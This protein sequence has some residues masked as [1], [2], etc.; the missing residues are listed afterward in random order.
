MPRLTPPLGTVTRKQAVSVL[1]REGVIT[2]AS[3]LEKLKG[4]KRV[5]LEGRTHG[6][7]PEDQILSIINS[8]RALQNQPPL[9]SIFDEEHKIVC[10]Q[11][12]T[13]DMLGVYTVAEK[14]FGHTTS[15]EDRMPLVERVPEGN[16]IVTDRGKVVSYIHI[17]PLLPSAMQK[18]LK[19]E[20]RGADIKADYLD[21]FKTGKVVSILI[22]S[23]GS[24]HE[25]KPIA[26]LYSQV[27]F[28]EMQQELKKWG[29]KGY[30]ID[31]VYA[32]SETP[33]GIDTAASFH[34]TSLGR[35]RGSKGKRRYAYVLDIASSDLPYLKPYKSALEKWHS[36]HQEEYE[37]AW[38]DWQER[39]SA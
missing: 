23:V 26:K 11:A 18:F 1:L 37:Q 13:S 19:G 27:L 10:R 28:R 5:V 8:R 33:S 25:Y 2:S 7:Y 24:Y 21:P 35:V 9:R 20:I 12:K 31:K 16:M 29:E 15:A 6:F 36:Q 17:Q 3:M 32:T 14:L 4:I 38:R 22:K 39:K 34:M 30:I